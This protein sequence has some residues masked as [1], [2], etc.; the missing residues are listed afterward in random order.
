MK[1]ARN[2]AQKFGIVFAN[3]GEERGPNGEQV[4]WLMSSDQLDSPRKC[5]GKKQIASALCDALERLFN[6]KFDDVSQSN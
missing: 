6:L 2:R 4:G 3:R 1:I 5:V